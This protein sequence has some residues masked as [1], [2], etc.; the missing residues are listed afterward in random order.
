[1]QNRFYY[2]IY[3]LD[4]LNY[5]P[6]LILT[7]ISNSIWQ[8]INKTYTVNTPQA[9]TLSE[10]TSQTLCV[11]GYAM[12]P[13]MLAYKHDYRGEG[14][15]EDSP[16]MVDDDDDSLDEMPSDVA[17]FQEAYRQMHPDGVSH[18]NPGQTPLVSLNATADVSSDIQAMA[19]GYIY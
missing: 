11:S 9:H 12:H 14:D 6:T 8:E 19:A 2:A 17:A 5:F 1:M 15:A 16:V 4:K 13:G 10:S 7:L 3:F 18:A